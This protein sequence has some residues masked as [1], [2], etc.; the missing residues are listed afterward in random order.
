LDKYEGD[1]QMMLADTFPNLRARA[2]GE[3][4]FFCY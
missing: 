1:V 3:K 4:I 2:I